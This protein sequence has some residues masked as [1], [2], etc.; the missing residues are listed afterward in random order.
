[1]QDKQNSKLIH[2]PEV[3]SLKK[4]PDIP[5]YDGMFGGVGRHNRIIV[6]C[7][8]CSKRLTS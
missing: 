7:V 3:S 1:M 6:K 2:H 8:R 5:I 4:V